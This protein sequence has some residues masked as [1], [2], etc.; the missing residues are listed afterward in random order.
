MVRALGFSSFEES[1]K[2]TLNPKLIQVY[3]GPCF[4]EGL[5]P[6][7]CGADD[8]IILVLEQSLGFKVLGL[9]FGI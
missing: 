1:A 7:V 2:E 5:V 9:G 8:D 4:G 6:G 3:F